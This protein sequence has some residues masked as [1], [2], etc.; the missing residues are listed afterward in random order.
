MDAV[1]R[2][3]GWSTRLSPLVLGEVSFAHLDPDLCQPPKR[4]A[5]GAADD[6]SLLGTY[7]THR[8]SRS[9]VLLHLRQIS[10]FESPNLARASFRSPLSLPDPIAESGLPGLC[11]S[12]L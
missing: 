8:A 9:L 10:V 3:L 5:F 11:F 2:A 6:P 7:D 1:R 12:L 4:T